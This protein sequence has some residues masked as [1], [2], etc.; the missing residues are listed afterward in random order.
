MKSRYSSPLSRTIWRR[1]GGDR[2]EV[3]FVPE[4]VHHA[5]TVAALCGGPPTHDDIADGA[6]VV[7]GVRE[8]VVDGMLEVAMVEVGEVFTRGDVALRFEIKAAETVNMAAQ[9]QRTGTLRLERS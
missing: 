1:S 9:R 7:P 4:E 5:Q 6:L 2:R 8:I 3:C